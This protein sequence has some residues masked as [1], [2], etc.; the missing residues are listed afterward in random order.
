MKQW[1]YTSYVQQSDTQ[2]FHYQLDAKYFSTY[3]TKLLHVS[4]IYPR[5]FH[6]VTCWSRCTAYMATCHLYGSLHINIFIHIYVYIH[7]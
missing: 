5:H 7:I 4:A 6:G 2:E 1:Y 3:Y